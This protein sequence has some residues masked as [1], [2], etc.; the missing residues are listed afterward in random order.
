MSQNKQWNV[1]ITKMIKLFH[2]F[3]FL[4]VCSTSENG[5]HPTGGEFALPKCGKFTEPTGQYR[6]LPGR[7]GKKYCQAGPVHNIVALGGEAG[8]TVQ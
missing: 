7:A 4:T 2:T 5:I 8:E 3:H 6:I 1:T